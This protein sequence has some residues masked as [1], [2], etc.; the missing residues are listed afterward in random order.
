M[1]ILSFLKVEEDQEELLIDFLLELII[2][3]TVSKGHKSVPGCRSEISR[4]S[5]DL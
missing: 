5:F 2:R 4:F 3:I 1:P